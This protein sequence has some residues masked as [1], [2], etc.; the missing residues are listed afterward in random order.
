MLAKKSYLFEQE[1]TIEEIVYIYD[2]HEISEKNQKREE[3]F[4]NML[5]TLR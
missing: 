1:D 3:L 4:T 2:I 5:V